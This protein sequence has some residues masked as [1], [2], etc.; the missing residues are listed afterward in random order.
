MTART[1][2]N[3]PRATRI[4]SNRRMVLRRSASWPAAC[5]SSPPPGTPSL[6]ARTPA[7]APARV[8]ASPPT[9]SP[10]CPPP[11]SSRCG[12]SGCSAPR[13][14]P[15]TAWA[16][17]A[18]ASGGGWHAAWDAATNVPSRLWGPGIPAPGAMASAAIAEQHARRVLAEH[19]ALLA[20]GAALTDFVLVSNHS[21][22]DLRSDQL[23]A[24]RRRPARSSVGEV[25][26]RFKR[27]RLF[28]IGSEALPDVKVTPTRAHGRAR[29]RRPR[30]R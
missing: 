9:S 19:L 17:F 27:D 4:G 11:A 5:S 24:A 3:F 10:R 15:S 23:R 14:A 1:Y 26:F 6:L 12:P 18:A 8:G 16:R 21:D 20:P 22:G 25:S 29:A 28:L 7:R 13:P 2:G 30:R